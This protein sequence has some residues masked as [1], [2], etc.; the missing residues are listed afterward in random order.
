MRSAKNRKGGS[1][2]A[3]VLFN[4]PVQR[5]SIDNASG[6]SGSTRSSNDPE[7]EILGTKAVDTGHRGGHGAS[8]EGDGVTRS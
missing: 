4:I 7:L 5:V 2:S 6:S 3:A 1:D 8:W